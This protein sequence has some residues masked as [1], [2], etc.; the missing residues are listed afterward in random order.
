MKQTDDDDL[1]F[2]QPPRKNKKKQLMESDD[3]DDVYG[4]EDDDQ[5]LQFDVQMTM[6]V[7]T[8][9]I[10]QVDPR[11]VFSAALTSFSQKST[12]ELKQLIDLL[13]PSH[14]QFVIQLY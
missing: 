2:Q 8:S 13:E 4:S 7:L 6:D 3:E 5:A 9:P 14:K 11:L 1:G 12:E 10:K